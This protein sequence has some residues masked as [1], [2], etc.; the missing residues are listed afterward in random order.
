MVA[1][2]T[3]TLQLQK[4]PTTL[5]PTHN[6]VSAAKRSF[7]AYFASCASCVDSSFRCVPYLRQ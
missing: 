7:S 5:P 6:L 4:P 2:D 3:L 1:I